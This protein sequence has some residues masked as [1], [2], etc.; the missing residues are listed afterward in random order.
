M[1]LADICDIEKRVMICSH[2][3]KQVNITFSIG[4]LPN[5]MKV[6]AFLSGELSN[7]AKYFSSF[8]NICNDNVND[9]RGT[10]GRS[11]KYTWTPWKYC[12]RM[13]LVKGVEQMKA[14][15]SK[16]RLADSTKR[17]KVTTFVG[18]KKNR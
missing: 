4:E 7:S 13:K 9:T 17:S 1:L 6:L 10:F 2:N 15:L 14:K 3:G 5:D 18:Q 8:A 11:N 16:Q 12:D